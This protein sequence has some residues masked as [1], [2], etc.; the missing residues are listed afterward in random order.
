[1]N[2]ELYVSYVPDSGTLQ[3][4]AVL[5]A[6]LRVTHQEVLHLQSMLEVEQEMVN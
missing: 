2:R 4:E 1:M 3:W 5:V 6:I